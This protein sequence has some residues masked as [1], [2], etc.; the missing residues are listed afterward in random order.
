MVYIRHL[1]VG[2]AYIEEARPAHV[3][4]HNRSLA[5]FLPQEGQHSNVI[6]ID[7][8]GSLAKCVYFKDG[9]LRFDSVETE[10]LDA[11]LEILKPLVSNNGTEITATGGGAYK[12]S[13][14]MNAELKV[15]CHRADEIECLIVGATFL[16]TKIPQEVFKWEGD[17]NGED[18]MVAM[19]STVNGEH[20]YPY[21][22][23]NIGSG[24]S[25]IKVDA[26]DQ[27]ERIGG[28]AV[29]GGT[30]W[31][32]LALLTPAKNFDE[33]LQMANQGDNKKVDMLVGDI[34]GSG[35]PR[36]GLSATT[37]AS[38]FA[39]AFKKE[40]GR[41]DFEAADISR[42]LVVAISYNIAQLAYLHA[43]YYNIE[44]IFFAG[45]YIRGHPQTI[46]T[47]AHG[48]K[49]WSKGATTAF[50]FRHEGY[51]GAVGAFLSS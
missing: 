38:F 36:M 19:S 13:D 11:F 24:V 27:F 30:L 6:G 21:M 23:V 48:I 50:F 34:Y 40:G 20:T 45:S 42:S 44:R 1:N 46:E 31:G 4:V 43:R 39:K 49:Y 12:Y 15:C 8:G 18:P 26:P 17:H 47:L 37:T 32:L 14:R 51:L 5:I 7:I 33:M 35:Y 10:K 2:G 22:L 25:F 28:T 16:M 9:A 3:D 41:Q 29:G